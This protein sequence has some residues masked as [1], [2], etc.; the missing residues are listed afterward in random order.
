MD[1]TSS[2]VLR[3]GTS[4]ANVATVR[5]HAVSTVPGDGPPTED[6]RPHL[7]PAL[8][9]LLGML[10]L[11][12]PLLRHVELDRV[13]I[14]AGQARGEARASIRSL[15]APP[16]PCRVHLAGHQLLFEM[17]L[18]PLWFRGCGPGQRLI[19]LVH[20]LWHIDERDHGMLA[21]ERRHRSGQ[22]P[23]RRGLVNQ[24]KKASRLLDPSLL[25]P[26]GHHG[27]V[28]M[29]SWLR[30]PVLTGEPVARRRFTMKDLYL[31]PVAMITGHRERSSWG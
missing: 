16:V 14:V 12:I 22:D 8:R 15:V 26:L 31:Q 17:T 4:C 5:D 25:A 11:E 19:T 2:A 1:A 3:P 23:A 13:L 10:C 18:R 24:V 29:P 30:R 21:P 28:L 9:R 7:A 6:L 20:E 27:E